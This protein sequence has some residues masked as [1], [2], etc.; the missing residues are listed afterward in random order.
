MEFI[1]LALLAGLFL[2]IAA[3]VQSPLILGFAFGFWLIHKG[4]DAN[5]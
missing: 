3:L 5:R 4:L 2:V 1:A